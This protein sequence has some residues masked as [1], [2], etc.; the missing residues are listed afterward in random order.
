M[1]VKGSSAPGI[2]LGSGT[3]VLGETLPS[4]A[5]S[6]VA[7][8]INKEKF[9]E[10]AKA[11]CGKLYPAEISDTLDTPDMGKIIYT[12]SL[13][14]LEFDFL[15]KSPVKLRRNKN[16]IKITGS[17]RGEMKP[18]YMKIKRVFF[19]IYGVAEPKISGDSVYLQFKEFGIE[20][21]SPSGR[22][23]SPKVINRIQA[24]LDPLFNKQMKKKIKSFKLGPTELPLGEKELLTAQITSAQVGKNTLTFCAAPAGEGTIEG[25]ELSPDGNEIHISEKYLNMLIDDLQESGKIPKEISVR[26]LG[27]KAKV[28]RFD[29]DAEVNSLSFTGRITFYWG[30]AQKSYDFKI[31]LTVFVDPDTSVLTCYTKGE[32]ELEDVKNSIPGWLVDAIIAALKALGLDVI[33]K[34]IRALCDVFDEIL[35]I[36]KETAKEIMGELEF[37]YGVLVFSVPIPNTNVAYIFHCTEIKMGKDEII[38]LGKSEVMELTPTISAG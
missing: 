32:P 7:F 30:G 13:K 15:P 14:D 5:G 29:L 27:G 20:D 8:Q 18:P 24:V 2:P 26:K 35:K 19:K 37:S 38:L 12:L 28:Y 1:D 10:A 4:T 17:A 23:L 36:L 22:T 25:F 9:V 21:F 6:G 16:A 11:C 34:V 3:E 31:P 33:G